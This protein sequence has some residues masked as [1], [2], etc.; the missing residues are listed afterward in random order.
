MTRPDPT[1]LVAGLAATTV[2]VGYLSYR[3]GT[4][5][6]LAGL[7]AASVPRDRAPRLHAS[8]DRL[9]E[10]MDVERPD[11]RIGSLPAPNALSV[12]SG[13]SG[14]IVFDAQ[15]LR[16]LSMDETETIMAHELAHLEGHDALLQTLAY[17]AL[18]TVVGMLL[19]VLLPVTLFATGLARAIALVRGRPAAWATN[20]IGRLRVRLSRGV[21]VVFALAT[22]AVRA[23]AGGREFAADER[24]AEVTRNPMALASALTTI[25]RLTGAP[26]GLLS[27]LTTGGDDAERL[28]STHPPT[29]KRVERLRAIADG[30]ERERW[31][32][33]PVD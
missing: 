1:V 18:Q 4:A 10:R 24:A 30:R 26:Q 22:V 27:Q 28:L 13:G 15:L 11:L 19:F 7:Q 14:V 32:T 9:V 3:V 33:I 8:L 23:H 29:E 21:L 17:A 12:G 2:V 16:S 25:D 20:P 6:L 5:R 31:T